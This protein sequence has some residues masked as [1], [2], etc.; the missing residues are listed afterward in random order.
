MGTGQDFTQSGCLKIIFFP[1]SFRLGKIKKYHLL[2]YQD[3]AVNY[4][5]FSPECFGA[6]AFLIFATQGEPLKFR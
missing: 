3:L 2:R 1:K 4:Y 6:K 5:S